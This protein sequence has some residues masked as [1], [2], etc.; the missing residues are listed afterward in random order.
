MEKLLQR[1]CISALNYLTP[2]EVFEGKTKKRLVKRKEKLHTALS[3]GGLCGRTWGLVFLI[4][5]F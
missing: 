1:G 2:K 4:G 5:T 3:R